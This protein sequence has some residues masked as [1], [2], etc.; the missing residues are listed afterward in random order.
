MEA[1]LTSFKS[2]QFVGALYINLIV[3]S[4]QRYT[5]EGMIVGDIS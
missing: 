2:T 5:S 3:I 1:I 4:V